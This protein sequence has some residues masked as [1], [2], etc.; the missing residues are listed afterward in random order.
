MNDQLIGNLASQLNCALSTHFFTIDLMIVLS[1]RMGTFNDDFHNY[2]VTAKRF[3]LISHS[4]VGDTHILDRAGITIAIIV[5]GQSTRPKPPI[6]TLM[7][8]LTG[9][10]DYSEARFVAHHAAVR[11]CGALQ[12]NCFDHWT[13]VLQG[14][15]REGIIDINGSAGQASLK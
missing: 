5:E 12:G 10:K 1:S 11:F 8:L 14:A 4:H 3:V 9:G 6:V 2:S 15:E 13:D 7:A